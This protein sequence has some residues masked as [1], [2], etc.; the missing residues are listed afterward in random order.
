MIRMIGVDSLDTL[1]DQTVPAGIR[2]PKGL[3]LPAA[4]SEEGALRDLRA[5]MD[6]NELR[7]STIGMG[8]A[9]CYTPGVIRRNILEN[10][11]WYTAYTHTRPRSP[12]G[13][14]EALPQF[15]DHGLRPLR[16]GH[17]NASLLDESTAAA[18]AMA[19]AREAKG[20]DA[21][22]VADDCHPQTIAL[23]ET[24]AEP[25]GVRLIVGR[26]TSSPTRRFSVH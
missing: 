18:E 11:G 16:H 3:N 19:M 23:L 8:Y 1:I 17:F 10:P 12:R 25:L 14:L 4:R 26:S 15:P 2:L 7:Q 9:G 13:R 6:R 21:F 24:R 20:G 22:F 5:M